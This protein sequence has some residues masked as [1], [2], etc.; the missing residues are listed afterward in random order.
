MRS[1]PMG[2]VRRGGWRPAAALLALLLAAGGAAPAGAAPPASAADPEV[3]QLRAQVHELRLALDRLD[4]S[5]QALERRSAATPAEATAL[6][7]APLPSAV[8]RADTSAT[9]LSVRERS[10]LAEQT[11]A[12]DA[13]AGWRAL[14]AG[15]N[16]QQ[17]R[18]LLGEPASVMKVSNRTGW[19]YTYAQLGTGSVFFSSAGVVISSMAPGRGAFGLN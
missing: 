7:A 12:A 3:A 4:A 19:V 15:M 13:L 10:V 14:Q 9:P 1:E 2:A 11:R 16:Q 8:S 17:V 18:E 5:L 6:S